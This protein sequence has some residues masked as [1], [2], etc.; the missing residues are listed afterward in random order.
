MPTENYAETPSD[1]SSPTTQGSA[2]DALARINEQIETEVRDQHKAVKD[3]K[4]RLQSQED[5]LD[6]MVKM[7]HDAGWKYDRIAAASGLSSKDVGT[8]ISRSSRKGKSNVETKTAKS[9]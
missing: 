4:L 7:A 5:R 1:G 2:F 6:E 3:A 8:R 9:S